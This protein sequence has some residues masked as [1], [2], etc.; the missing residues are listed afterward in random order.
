MF[1]QHQGL[2]CILYHPSNVK[3]GRTQEA[4]EHIW[5]SQSQ[6]TKQIFQTIWHH[7]EHVSQG[8]KNKLGELLER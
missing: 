8:E 3:A 5:D 6:L 1:A 2:F 7:A 4:K